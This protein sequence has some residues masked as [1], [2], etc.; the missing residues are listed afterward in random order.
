MIDHEK[1]LTA[2][3]VDAV[4]VIDEHEL[5]TASVSKLVHNEAKNFNRDDCF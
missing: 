2:L 5:K 3:T 1:Y 4:E